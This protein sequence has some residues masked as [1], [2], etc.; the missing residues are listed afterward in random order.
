MRPPLPPFDY[1]SAL[2][3]VRAVEDHWN[4][5]DPQKVALAYTKDSQWRNRGLFINGREEI[6]AFLATKWEREL[7]YRLIKG[8]FRFSGN[9]I[10]VRFAYEYHNQAGQWYRAYGN[11]NWIFDENGLMASRYASINDLA[12]NPEDRLFKW[13]QGSRPKDHLGL[14]EL[15]L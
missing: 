10:A 3:N 2:A 9:K 6:A 12:I 14:N 11:E 7:E 5:R 4:S 15:G 1:E 8:L 13:P